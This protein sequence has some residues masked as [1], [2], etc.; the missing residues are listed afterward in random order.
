M[1]INAQLTLH[2]KMV[3]FSHFLKNNLEIHKKL[4]SLPPC[5]S[6]NHY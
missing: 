3:L 2:H 6:Y 4:I 5:R 1:S